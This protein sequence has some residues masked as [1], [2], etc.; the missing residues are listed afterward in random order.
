MLSVPTD[1]KDYIKTSEGTS[2][3]ISLNSDDDELK[4]GSCTGAHWAD[5]SVTG[6]SR[7]LVS[8]GI[9]VG[10]RDCV[11]VR[12][13]FESSLCCDLENTTFPIKLDLPEEMKADNL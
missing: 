6:D 7:W 1:F 4:S 11:S 5:V 8:G 2:F 9:W 10:S 12:D 13:V 3:W